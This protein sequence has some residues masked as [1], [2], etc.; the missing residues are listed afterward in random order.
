[1][2]PP[3]NPKVIRNIATIEA[4]TVRL[5]KSSSGRIGSTAR[6]SIQTKTPAEDEADED[7]AADLRVVPAAAL[8]VREPE[9]EGDDGRR[10]DRRAKVVDLLDD[11]RVPHRRQEAPQHCQRHDP[12]RQ[13]DRGRSSAS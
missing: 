1:M 2:T 6:D 5:R 9:Q 10:K 7:Q 11:L 13:V 3:K 12:E 4:V 8:G